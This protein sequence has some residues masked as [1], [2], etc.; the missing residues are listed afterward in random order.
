M[1]SPL[2]Q[3]FADPCGGRLRLPVVTLL[4]SFE[5]ISEAKSTF[6]FALRRHSYDLATVF[7]ATVKCCGLRLIQAAFSWRVPS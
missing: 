6:D 2:G 5:L 4:L 3:P 7:G 1:Q